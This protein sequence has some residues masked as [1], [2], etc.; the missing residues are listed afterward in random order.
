M[1]NNFFIFFLIFSFG[2]IFF[3]RKF[4]VLVDQKIEKHKKYS[5]KKKSLLIGGILLITFLNYHYLFIEQDPILCLF[6]NFAFLI[7]VMSDLKKINNASLRLFLQCV[8]VLFFVNFLN[9]KITYT[10]IGFFD[11]LLTMSLINIFFVTFCLLVLKNGSNFIDGINGLAIG[12]FLIIFL[13]IFLNLNYF[14]YDKSLLENLIVILLIIFLLNLYG[15]LY[16]GDSGSYTIGLFTGVFL[17]NF[18][19]NNNSI[20]P[21]FIIV[22]LWYP[23]FELLFSMIRRLLKKIKTHEPDTA[24][25]H[26]LMYK[27]IKIHFKI[28]NDNIS[29]LITTFVINFYNFLCFFISAKYLYSSDA[30]LKIFLMNIFVYVISY[31]YLKKTI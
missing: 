6:I 24:H 29:H 23:C 28:K 16:L 30:L 21:Y 2:L 26:H 27:K 20:S 17:I 3:C 5:S 18:S 12:Y 8:T 19:F 4:N 14:E 25:L 10:R 1:I 22:L 15:V 9:I 7:G 13:I 11:Q 31:N